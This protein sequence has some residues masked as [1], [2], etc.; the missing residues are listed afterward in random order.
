VKLVLLALAAVL[1]FALFAGP[2]AAAKPTKIVV[3]LNDPAFEAELADI[4]T[5]A[6]G[7]EIAADTSGHVIVLLFGGRKGETR[8]EID[9]FGLHATFTNVEKGAT[10]SIVD[11]GPDIYSFDRTTG[12]LTVAITGRSLTGSGVFGRVVIDTV[13]G[14]VISSAGNPQGDWI[15][16]A[17]AA[18]T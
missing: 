4:L 6:C 8:P 10:Y 3:D 13:T 14:E 12:H 2:A 9:V 15:G 1:G 17:C 11:V 18:L 5:T 7:T 16:N